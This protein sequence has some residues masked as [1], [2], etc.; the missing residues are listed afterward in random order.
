MF[1]DRRDAGVQLAGKLT[2]YKGREGML[3][4]ALPR[5]GVVTGLEIA[6][7][8]NAPLDI[9]IVRKM[10]YPG[11]EELAIGAIS[12]TGTVVLNERIISTSGIPTK[13]IEDEITRQK[14]EIVRRTRLYRGGKSLEKLEGKTIIL[15]DDGVAT[16]ATMKAAIAT[17]KM[18]KIGRLVVSIPVSPIQTADELRMMADEFIY[19]NIPE[20]FKAVGN[21]YRD[22]SQ[23]SDDEVVEILRN[24][25]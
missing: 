2:H 1:T 12:E 24:I 13:Y 25:W 11:N 3:V 8:I 22:F 9:L 23:V 5:G 6:R 14:E 17:L 21:Y 19:L 16:G 20:D 7:V 18:E 15:V 10:G 4:L